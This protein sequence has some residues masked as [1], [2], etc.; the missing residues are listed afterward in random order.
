M[1]LPAGNV[2]GVVADQRYSSR[3]AVRVPLA[4]AAPLEPLAPAGVALVAF[5]VTELVVVVRESAKMV[6]HVHSV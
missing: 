1:E 4:P 2:D 6:R 3:I 5:Q